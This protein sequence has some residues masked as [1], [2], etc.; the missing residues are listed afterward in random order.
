MVKGKNEKE[1]I[2]IFEFA[3]EMGI[4][5]IVS[6]PNAEHLDLVE[7]LCAEYKIKLA[8]HNHPD[9]TPY[10][11][12]TIVL[13]ALD[14]RNEYMGVCADV[15]HWTRSG[16]DAV[17]CLQML[18]GKIFETHFKDVNATDKS[19]HSVVWGEGKI[20]MPGILKELKRQ[21]FK[22]KHVIE[23]E[24]NWDNSVPDIQQSIENF[25]LTLSEI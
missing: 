15:G 17:E 25:T 21:N 16:L 13:K 8:L 6:E 20:D 4:K 2:N 23:Y 1:W 18:E 11:N 9:P 3:K 7:D 24:Y 10:W 5:I 12:P 14:G 22:G 19:G